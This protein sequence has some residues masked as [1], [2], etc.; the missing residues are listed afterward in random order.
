MGHEQTQTVRR[1]C[2]ARAIWGME[3]TGTDYEHVPVT[4]GADSK[5]G[6]YL[7][8]NPNGRIPA[9]IDG[10]L[11]L[12]ESMEINHYLAKRHGGALYPADA[13]DEARAGQWSVW[14]IARPNRCRCR[15]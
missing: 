3:E 6:N 2:V 13:H 8:V 5:A 12:L 1:V 10:D 9:L 15:S 14:V 11:R 7:A 4:Y